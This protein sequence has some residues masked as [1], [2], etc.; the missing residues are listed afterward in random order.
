MITTTVPSLEPRAY[1]AKP[2]PQ[3]V[4]MHFDGTD[5]S[6]Q[7]VKS[8]L[9]S[10]IDGDPVVV[11]DELDGEEFTIRSPRLF[12]AVYHF[13][14]GIK[15]AELVV[16]PGAWIWIDEEMYINAGQQIP[17]RSVGYVPVS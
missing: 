5:A 14:T 4:V 17:T 16:E 13:Q 7:A 2:T 12:N 9:N 11:D 10:T 3:L 8:W 1:R 6:F 15:P